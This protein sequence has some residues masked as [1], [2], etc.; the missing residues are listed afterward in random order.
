MAM[1]ITRSLLP[2]DTSIALPAIGL[3]N[4]ELVQRNLKR[5]IEV[6]PD[7]PHARRSRRSDGPKAKGTRESPRDCNHALGH[8]MTSNMHFERVADVRLIRRGDSIMQS[9]RLRLAVKTASALL[10]LLFL[11]PSV[12]AADESRSKATALL[13]GTYAFT[14][15]RSCIQTPVAPGFDPATL[16][17]L[18]D[19]ERALFVDT[20]IIDFDGKGGAKVSATEIVQLNPDLKSA[21]Q[22][23]LVT[24]LSS[25]CEGTYAA[26]RS[27]K[28][29]SE[30]TCV[31]DLGN[32]VTLTITPFRA[33][34]HIGRGA[35]VVTTSEIEGTLQTTTVAAGDV[36][37]SKRERVCV[38]SGTLLKMSN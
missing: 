19:G 10:P 4:R 14:V 21:G 22:I 18:V 33:Q 13:R 35:N 11:A 16:R 31:A 34:G 6:S 24:G 17:L 30:L 15:Y 23:P 26:D 32:G 27:M 25:S 28:F 29:S 12:N 8:D 38:T 37:L 3:G 1:S 2:A 5:R 36:V 7:H 9:T 20:G